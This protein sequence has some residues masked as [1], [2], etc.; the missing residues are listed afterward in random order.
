MDEIESGTSHFLAPHPNEA[1][2][3]YIPM[4]LAKIVHFI[5]EPPEYYGNWIPRLVTL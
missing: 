4:S 5:Y 2:A 1:D 3:F